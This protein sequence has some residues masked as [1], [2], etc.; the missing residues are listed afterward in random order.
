MTRAW[1]KRTNSSK[2]EGRRNLFIVQ[3]D[4][5]QRCKGGALSKPTG[6]IT[7]PRGRG[8]VGEGTHCGPGFLY[9][10]NSG[11]E[12][13][14]STS[15]W[16]VVIDVRHRPWCDQKYIGP[17]RAKPSLL[18]FFAA[19]RSGPCPESTSA[20]TFSTCLV[21][22]GSSVSWLRLQRCPCSLWRL[23]VAASL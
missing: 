21:L 3:F 17:G 22:V 5:Y 2:A 18:Q 4:A 1:E 8:P 9:P 6:P 19:T 13:R 15:H 14:T 16:R 7:I 12:A 11:Q 20:G 10:G 23:V